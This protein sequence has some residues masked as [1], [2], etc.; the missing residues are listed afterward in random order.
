M[1]FEKIEAC[2]CCSCVKC[3]VAFDASLAKFYTADLCKVAL[4][5]RVSISS[6]CC[7]SCVTVDSILFTVGDLFNRWLPVELL[8]VTIVRGLASLG[9]SSSCSFTKTRRFKLPS[10]A[11]GIFASLNTYRCGP[12]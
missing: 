10:L 11:F 9:T 7:V 1:V 4:H 12:G 8:K 3:S 6:A 2:S 5:T